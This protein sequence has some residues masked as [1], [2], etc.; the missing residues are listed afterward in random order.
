MNVLVKRKV[1]AVLMKNIS[2]RDFFRG[3]CWTSATER[4][5]DPRVTLCI[6]THDSAQ[7]RRN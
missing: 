5:I 4:N 7:S 2:S 1:A 3:V 6:I